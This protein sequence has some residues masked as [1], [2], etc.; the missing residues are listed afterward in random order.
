[1]K[2]LV[3][4][5]LAIS[6]VSSPLPVE[7]RIGWSSAS[8]RWVP[9][10]FALQITSD[11]N[12][13]PSRPPTPQAEGRATS[14]QLPC[15]L[16]NRQMMHLLGTHPHYQSDGSCLRS[17]SLFALRW[18]LLASLWEASNSLMNTVYL[19]QR[20]FGGLSVGSQSGSSFVQKQQQRIAATLTRAGA[21]RYNA[22]SEK[23]GTRG[24]SLSRRRGRKKAEKATPTELPLSFPLH[25]HLSAICIPT[26]SPQAR[27][28]STVYLFSILFRLLI[29][30]L[31][32]P[33][34]SSKP[35]PN[36][37]TEQQLPLNTL[38]TT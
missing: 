19:Y 15:K 1:M 18:I 6:K 9:V 16:K 23:R 22:D 14:G 5:I 28:T 37:G 29:N 33:P 17:C 25:H 8:A 13:N 12:R 3:P 27:A 10:I 21:G 35:T 34:F 20:G 24:R 30:S 31:V 26:A 2:P 36:L 11:T 7:W 4:R 38:L 32:L